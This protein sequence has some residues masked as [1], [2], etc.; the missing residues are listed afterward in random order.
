MLLRMAPIIGGNFRFNFYRAN[1][2]FGKIEYMSF[3][4]KKEGQ[5]LFRLLRSSTRL[6]EVFTIYYP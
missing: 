1:L 6:P 5:F 2:P 4:T 3:G